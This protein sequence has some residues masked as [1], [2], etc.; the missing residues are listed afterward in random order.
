MLPRRRRTGSE[1]ENLLLSNERS[2]PQE[3]RLSRV[4]SG[5]P[6]NVTEDYYLEEDHIEDF[7]E[8]EPI[9]S[10]RDRTSEFINTIQTLQGRNIARAVAVKDPR[11]SR[12]IQSHSEFMLI[13]K[14]V[15]K[16]LASTYA[17]L[18]KLTLLAKRKSLFDDRTA[19]IQELTYIIKGDLNSLNQQIAQ[20][21]NISKRQK[22]STNGRHL[23]SHSSNIVLTLQ[24]KLAT[25]STDF[26]QILEVRTEN[27]RHQKNRRDQFSQGGLPPPNNASIGQS[28]LLFQ[29]QDHVS[30]GMENQPL[31]PQ[32][33]QS[34]MQVALM[35][36]QTD[37]Y[38]QSRAET[39][40]NIESTIVE[41]G[42][43]FQ[44]LA[45]MVKEQEEMVER[46]DTNVQDAELNI[47]AAHSQILKYF[48]SVSSNRWLMIKVFG[49]LI[50]FFI[51]F[52]VFL[53]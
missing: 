7:I 12:A 27:L 31:I 35:Y 28:S 24:S 42:G 41:L 30:V 15:G 25:M 48:K 9:M 18:E 13:A 29:E 5:Y 49:V 36:D 51:F 40:Q 22:H 6:N 53:A 1:S 47:E 39:M 37:N 46:I 16:N 44:Q 11:K 23:Q 21:Q 3:D 32:Q 45:H 20:L 43:I 34:Q 2:R 8:P 17:K 10:A 19:E 26:K 33:S 14:N 50:F 4:N 38:L 52:I